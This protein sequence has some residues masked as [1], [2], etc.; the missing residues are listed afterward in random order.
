MIPGK[1]FDK[2]INVQ[3]NYTWLGRMIDSSYLPLDNAIPLNVKSWSPL[4]NGGFS[5]ETTHQLQSLYLMRNSEYLECPVKT[6][7][8]RDAVHWVG[9]ITCASVTLANLPAAEK[10]Q[11]KLMT[12]GVSNFKDEMALTNNTKISE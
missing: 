9:T 10:K 11:V 6:I 1:V 4:G 3:N 7:K 8:I 12:A 5:L 2:K